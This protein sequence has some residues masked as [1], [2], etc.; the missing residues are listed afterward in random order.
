MQR[1]YIGSQNDEALKLQGE[2]KAELR[3]SFYS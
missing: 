1:V 3:G 2:A